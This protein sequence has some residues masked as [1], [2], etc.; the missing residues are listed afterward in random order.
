[1][2]GKEYL[3]ISPKKVNYREDNY[4]QTK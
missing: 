2:E 1:M 4:S 3:S